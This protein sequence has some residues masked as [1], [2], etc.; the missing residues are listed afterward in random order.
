MQLRKEC[1]DLCDDGAALKPIETGKPAGKLMLRLNLKM[2][3]IVVN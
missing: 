3:K 1:P 2:A